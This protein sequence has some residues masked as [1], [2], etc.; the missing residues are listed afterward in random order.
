M[1]KYIT[2][3]I[4][5]VLLGSSLFGLTAIAYADTTTIV[6]NFDDTYVLADL[7]DATVF[8]KKFDTA[9]YPK[10]SKGEL[11]LLDFTEYCFSTKFE[12]QYNYG[13]YLYVYNPQCIAFED[14]A[15]NKIQI[16]TEYNDKG[17]PTKYEKFNISI[18]SA[19]SD[20]LFYKFKVENVSTI[21]DRIA[22][23][24]NERQYDVSGVELL[25]PKATNA[26]DYKVGGTWVYKGYAKGCHASSEEE[27]TLTSE[28]KSLQTIELDDLQF[29]YYRKWKSLLNAD[30][31]TSV[32]FSVPNSIADNYDILYSIQAETYQYL[33]SPIFAVYDRYIAGVNGLFANYD[34]LYADLLK[35]RNIN[36]PSKQNSSLDRIFYWDAIDTGSGETRNT[37]MTGYNYTNSMYKDF[38]QLPT[39]AWIFQVSAKEDF[40][41]SSEKLLNYMRDYSNEFKSHTIQGKYAP[42]LFADK[43]YSVY[44]NYQRFENGYMPLDIDISGKYDFTLV[45]S[46]NKYNFWDALLG[47]WDRG[48]ESE[49]ITPIVEVAYKDLQGLSEDQISEKYY[50]NKADVAKFKEYVRNQTNRRVYLFH[51]AQSDY[52]TTVVSNNYGVVGYMAQEV[53]YLDFDIIS[54][55]YS[56]DGV[57]TIIPVVASPIDIIG[58]VEPGKDIGA[59]AGLNLIA[60]IL[61][62]VLVVAII[63][64]VFKLFGVLTTKSKKNKEEE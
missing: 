9:D 31:L 28:I 42:A 13:L 30:Q 45:G 51:F 61:G 56:K 29:T 15:L 39:L 2:I 17:E 52:F 33:T 46:S 6:E 3:L 40:S 5:T 1:K 38:V 55:G 59:N 60:L 25:T 37:A 35:Q 34:E 27:S 26:H 4:L 18:C 50:V 44:M 57:I 32:Y 49:P 64:L 62:I 58:G 10:D 53:A 41:V 11:R 14:S 48:A 43:Y 47:R 54:M 20:R 23:S 24:S 8:G 16:A 22:L 63:W 19:T 12:L 7:A 21:Y 36:T